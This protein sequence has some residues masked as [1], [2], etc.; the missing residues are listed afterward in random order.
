[1]LKFLEAQKKE[2]FRKQPYFAT[3]YLMALPGAL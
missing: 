2:L 3:L 1:M